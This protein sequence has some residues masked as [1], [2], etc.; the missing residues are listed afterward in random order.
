MK[1]VPNPFENIQCIKHEHGEIFAALRAEKTLELDD[2]MAA[3]IA[4]EPHADVA[5]G[6]ES[7]KGRSFAAEIAK[8][9]GLGGIES[10]YRC[11]K[12]P[13]VVHCAPS[14]NDLLDAMAEELRNPKSERTMD[15]AIREQLHGKSD[16][17]ILGVRIFCE[18]SGVV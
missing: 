15:T 11:L 8:N 9:H 17:F 16:S 6:A 3:Y 14:G 13:T 2:E 5:D 1:R 4:S 10:L 18:Q 7:A 12:N